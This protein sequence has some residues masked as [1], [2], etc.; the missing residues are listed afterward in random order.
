DFCATKVIVQNSYFG[1]SSSSFG[2]KNMARQNRTWNFH[3]TN[4][5]KKFGSI[6]RCPEMR[7]KYFKKFPVVSMSAYISAYIIRF[8]LETVMHSS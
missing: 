6:P 7:G 4:G 5:N 3:L 8:Q 1:F 2:K